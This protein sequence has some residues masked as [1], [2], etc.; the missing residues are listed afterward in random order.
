M[1]GLW[2]LYANIT[3]ITILF[4]WRWPAYMDDG[5]DWYVAI[6][7]QGLDFL[8]Y[9]FSYLTLRRAYLLYFLFVCLATL[10]RILIRA[11]ALMLINACCKDGLLS[12]GC[13]N[14]SALRFVAYLH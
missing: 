3:I 9:R 10:P 14:V 12:A 4:L 5:I 8:L 7:G 6:L 13:L 2:Y 11:F 1:Y